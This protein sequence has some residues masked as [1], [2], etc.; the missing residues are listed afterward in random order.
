MA[1]GSNRQLCA[2]SLAHSCWCCRLQALLQIQCKVVHT[3]QVVC[4]FVRMPGGC[5]VEGV[6]LETTAWWKPSVG[7]F[8]ERPGH[9]NSVWNYWSTDGTDP[10]SD[11]Y[12]AMNSPLLILD[13]MQQLFSPLEWRCAALHLDML[14]MPPMCMRECWMNF[15]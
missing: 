5:Y 8:W 9:Y 10:L 13:T 7:P 3:F 2:N 6:T 14:W 15:N 4:R 12:P 1:Q 11:K